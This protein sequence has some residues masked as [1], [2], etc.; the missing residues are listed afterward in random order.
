M[1]PIDILRAHPRNHHQRI[2]LLLRNG[3]WG[4]CSGCPRDPDG[5]IHPEQCQFTRRYDHNIYTSNA[6]PLTH[7]DLFVAFQLGRVKK[8]A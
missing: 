6:D 3:R 2:E 4:T 5:T 8:E 1:S 7:A